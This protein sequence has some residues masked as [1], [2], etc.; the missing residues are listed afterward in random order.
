MKQ[1]TSYPVIRTAKFSQTVGFYEDVFGL[2]PAYE[3]EGYIRLRHMDSGDIALAIID[4]SHKFIPD[5]L[6]Q[7]DSANL[8]TCI[9]PDLDALY[10]TVY[11]EGLEIV[12]SPTEIGEGLRHFMF[13]D[14]YND[15]VINIMNQAISTSDTI[16]KK[17]NPSGQTKSSSGEHSCASC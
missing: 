4:A 6:H 8:F 3:S 9:V 17:R 2:I 15:V 5:V 11:M 10:D 7:S 13:A 16:F 1:F 12:K 14:P